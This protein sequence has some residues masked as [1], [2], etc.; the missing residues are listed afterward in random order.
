M[1][2]THPMEGGR[3]RFALNGRV[4]DYHEEGRT[5]QWKQNVTLNYAVR[6]L[7]LPAT[8]SLSFTAL[9]EGIVLDQIIV[10]P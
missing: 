6:R 1:E 9:D 3:L 8:E 4:F 5:E 10:K 2:A 7:R